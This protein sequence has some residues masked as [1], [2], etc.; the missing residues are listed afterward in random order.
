LALPI[1]IPVVEGKVDAT[2]RLSHSGSFPMDFAIQSHVSRFSYTFPFFHNSRVIE[3]LIILFFNFELQ[4]DLYNILE[5]IQTPSTRQHVR[6]I[7]HHA[8][9]RFSSRFSL[10]SRRI[11]LGFQLYFSFFRYF[12][13]FY[14][15]VLKNQDLDDFPF[16]TAGQHL[17]RRTDLSDGRVARHHSGA[18]RTCWVVALRK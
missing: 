11:G 13:L 10:S 1:P 17:T 16:P 2:R 12:C 5:D 18:L 9:S 6:F 14:I 3:I 4:V 15:L 7:T 8:S